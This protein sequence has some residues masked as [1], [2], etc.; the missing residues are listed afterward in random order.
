MFTS[1][2]E[3]RLSL[4]ADNADER[5][6]PVAERL[7]ILGNARAERFAA[8]QRALDEA[9]RVAKGVTMTPTQLRAAGIAVSQDGGYRSAYQ[10]L[11]YPDIVVDRLAALV[12]ELAALSA[13]VREALEIEARYAVYL[14]RQSADA[15]AVRKEE[16]T[17]IPPGLDFSEIA[18]L[19]N[20]LRHKLSIRKPRTIA[21]AQKLD[22]MTP[23]GLALII[24][25]IQKAARRQ[26]A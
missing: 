6:T 23:A 26:A 5:L 11:S 24:A 4:R 18:G 20:E 7:G 14:E 10:I 19:S 9:R 17:M 13:P 2:A 12:P 16:N 1:R 3:F 25:H 15:A 21:D 8:R 22:G